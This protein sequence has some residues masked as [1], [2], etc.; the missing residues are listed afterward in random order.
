MFGYRRPRGSRPVEDCP[1]A[2]VSALGGELPLLGSGGVGGGTG[3]SVDSTQLLADVVSERRDAMNHVV[4]FILI[5]GALAIPTAGPSQEQENPS[6]PGQ[7]PDPSTYQG[8]TVLQQQSDQQDQSYRQQQQEQSQGYQQQYQAPQYGS[9]G[10]GMA[11]RQG[12]NGHDGGWN[13]TPASR[14]NLAMMQAAAFARL[15]G[16]VELGPSTE[17]PRYF[18]IK[19]HATANEKPVLM[20]W[21][22]ARQHCETMANGLRP[23]V[24]AMNIRQSDITDRMIV[25][26]ADGRMS[27]GDF[28]YTR[29]HNHAVLMNYIRTH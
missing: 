1:S 19:R 24:Q 26:V 25:A 23:D 22:A 2:L 16:L 13:Q 18:A 21:L 5:F 17:D 7:I 11:S 3:L 20:K 12:S 4:R 8:S 28:N 10:N 14:C 15:R 27:Y 9:D 6:T 29:A